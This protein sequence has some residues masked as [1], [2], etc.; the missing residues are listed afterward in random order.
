MKEKNNR[1]VFGRY[2]KS[3][4]VLCIDQN[5]SKLGVIP[6]QEALRLASDIGLEL[7]QVAFGKDNVPTCKIVDLGKYKY[8]Q[9]KKEKEVAKKQREAAH[10]LKEI[11]IRPGTE[12]NDLKVKADKISEFLSEGHQVKITVMFRGRELAHKEVGEEALNLLLSLVPNTQVLSPA[13][14]E[15]R[16]LSV[17]VKLAL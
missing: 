3:Q 13:K 10:K 11:K 2:I 7:V 5:G 9:S 16:D 4:Q 1:I 17:T 14:M 8:D 12:E 15:G 6:T